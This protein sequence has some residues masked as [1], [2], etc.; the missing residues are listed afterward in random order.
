MSDIPKLKLMFG[1]RGPYIA[2]AEDDSIDGGLTV[3]ELS[4]VIRCAEAYPSEK[5][6]HIATAKICLRNQ[7]EIERLEKELRIAS[8]SLRG[9]IA[10]KTRWQKR[11]MNAV[12]KP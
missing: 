10:E 8:K 9:Q 3:K 11:Y 4:E 12:S 5:K 7:K 2:S 1:L 6:G